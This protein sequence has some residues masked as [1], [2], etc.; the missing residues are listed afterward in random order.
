MTIW[1]WVQPVDRIWKV[2]TDSEKGV[3]SV[4]N[5]KEELVIGQKNLKKEAVLLIEKNFLEVVATRLTNKK[6]GDAAG[7][8]KSISEYN[9]MYA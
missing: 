4:Y 1:A 7:F 5:E 2:V 8:K 6:S 3:V 9:S